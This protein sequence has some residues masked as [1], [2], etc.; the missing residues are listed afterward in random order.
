M[1]IPDLII[2]IAKFTIQIRKR[3]HYKLSTGKIVPFK[4]YFTFI[5]KIIID[6]KELHEQ[7]EY[8]RRRIKQ[9]KDSISI[10]LFSF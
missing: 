5:N 2:K 10:L 4:I 1:F 3:F 9:K 6:G 7:Y 8:A